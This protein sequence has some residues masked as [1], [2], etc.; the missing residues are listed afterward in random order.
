MSPSTCPPAPALPQH[1]TPPS[2]PPSPP[3]SGWSSWFVR[4]ARG[5]SSGR[6]P[7]RSRTPTSYGRTTVSGSAAGAAPAVLCCLPLLPATDPACLHMGRC[8]AY[9]LVH[10]C[11]APGQRR[12]I[13]PPLPLCR[14]DARQDRHRPHLHPRPQ[15][16]AARPR[17]KLQ[18]A[19]GVSPN[20]GAHVG[21][22]R[23]AARGARGQEA[24][25]ELRRASGWPSAERRLQRGRLTAHPARYYYPHA[26]PAPPCVAPPAGGEERAAAARRRGPAA[27]CAHRLRLP[28]PGEGGR[29]S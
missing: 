14:Q 9:S 29:G 24:R 17:G 28:A 6:R 25:Q 21:A 16:Q 15:A 1:H 10:A 23:G 26:P 7:R 19:Q 11:P 20:R 13:P 22:C 18:P 12:S 2:L 3:P 8:R 27:V 5:G 4:C